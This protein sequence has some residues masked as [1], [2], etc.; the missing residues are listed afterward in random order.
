MKNRNKI[1]DSGFRIGEQNEGSLHAALK[2]W[3]SQPNDTFEINVDG[4]LIDVVRG[5]E[6]FEIQTRNF[7][8]IRKKLRTLVKEHRLNLVYPISLEK[9]IIKIDKKDSRVKSRRK[10]PKKGRTIDI[11]DELVRIPDLVEIDNF[12]LIV[13]M[14]R[15]EEIRCDDGKGSWRRKGTSIIDRKLLEVVSETR[16]NNKADFL[17]FLPEHLEHPFSTKDLAEKIGCPRYKAR[18]ITYC[19]K[20]MQLIM[21]VGKRGNFLLYEKVRVSEND[22]KRGSERTDF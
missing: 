2:E 8:A 15:E 11:F 5:D 13:L 18:R 21:Q 6:L 1:N 16:F 22:I 12:S 9:W 14:I 3:I 20:K 17:I 4:F 7:S 19:L 10:S